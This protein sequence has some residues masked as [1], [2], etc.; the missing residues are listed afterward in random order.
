MLRDE[1]SLVLKLRVLDVELRAGEQYLHHHDP[2][3][4]HHHH[5]YHRGFDSQRYTRL[6]MGC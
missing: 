5:H 3:R 6:G 1:G 4:R 2:H